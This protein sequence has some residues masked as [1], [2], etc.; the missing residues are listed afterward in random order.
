MLVLKTKGTPAAWRQ[1]RRFTPPYTMTYLHV[2]QIEHTL[3]KAQLTQPTE[4]AGRLGKQ[5]WD[6]YFAEG[7]FQ[8]ESPDWDTGLRLAVALNRQTT[9][10][11]ATPM[12]YVHAGLAAASS[13]THYLSF[14]PQ[15]R[16]VARAAGLRVLPEDI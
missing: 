10:A 16:A 12:M 2:V 5:T 9:H 8:V 6:R 4:L 15:F 11:E 7:V 14:H 3:V 1:V 13:A